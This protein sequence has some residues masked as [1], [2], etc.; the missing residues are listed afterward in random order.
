MKIGNF[1]SV[2][3]GEKGFEHN[4]S[5]HIQVPLEGMARLRAAGHDVHLITNEY[6][7]D[8]SLP[9]CLD[10]DIPVHQVTDSRKRGGI[11]TR[12]SEQGRGLRFASL[13]RQ[14]AQIKQICHEHEFDVLH[15]HGYN[16]TAHLGG[17]LRLLGL[18]T[19]TVCTVFAAYFPERLPLITRRLWKRLDAVVAGTDCVVEHFAREGITVDRFRHGIIR[20]P[21]A[22]HGDAEIGPRRRILFWRDPSV[23]NGADLAVAAYRTLAPRYPQFDFDFAIRPHWDQVPGIDELEQEFDNVHVHRFP[24]PDGVTLPGLLLESIC[25]IQPMRH[26]SINPQL[27]I[28]ESLVAGIA[29]IA[30]DL[31]SNRELVRDGVTGRLVGTTDPSDLTQALDELLADPEGTLAMGQ[32]AMADMAERWN[33]DHLVGDLE[34]VYTRIR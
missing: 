16:R 5:G 6:G 3:A 12:D 11:L 29:T 24:Y 15:L 33:W 32:A 27:V 18:R 14:V 4:V 20:D 9:A 1:I 13:L 22:E 30:S 2:V 17:G 26:L 34:A 21:R 7:E 23:E 25:V 31:D 19:P 8:R 10:P 28:A